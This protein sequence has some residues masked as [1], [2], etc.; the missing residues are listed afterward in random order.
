MVSYWWCHTTDRHYLSLFQ[1]V[2]CQFMSLLEFSTCLY[3]YLQQLLEFSGMWGMFIHFILQSIQLLPAS[4]SNRWVRL[5]SDVPS[6]TRVL[7]EVTNGTSLMCSWN[8]C[9]RCLHT[10]HAV[11]FGACHK[12]AWPLHRSSHYIPRSGWNRKEASDDWWHEWSR[13]NTLQRRE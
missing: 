1:F 4:S 9:V 5:L 8:S 13:E 6:L 2:M 12:C 10:K 11:Q 3:H 7:H